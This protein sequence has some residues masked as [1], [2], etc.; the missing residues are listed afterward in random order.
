MKAKIIAAAALLLV[1][2]HQPAEAKGISPTGAAIVGGALG[3]IQLAEL[4]TH[5]FFD[6]VASAAAASGGGVMSL[7]TVLLSLTVGV[8]GTSRSI[9][10]GLSQRNPTSFRRGSVL[11]GLLAPAQ[12][13]AVNG[14][15]GG[16]ASAL[17]L[18]FFK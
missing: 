14:F 2:V 16:I 18:S 1:S 8:V 9:A 3:G 15:L 11:S 17:V 10:A 4:A 5:A 6:D 13:A 12:L 7:K